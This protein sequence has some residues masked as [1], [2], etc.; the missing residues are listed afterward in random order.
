MCIWVARIDGTIYCPAHRMIL[1][2]Y[3]TEHYISHPFSFYQLT[4]SRLS[5]HSSTSLS[6]LSKSLLPPTH[7]HATHLSS[8]GHLA[9]CEL[10]I[11]LSLSL[12]LGVCPSLLAHCVF[13]AVANLCV[14]GPVGK[15]SAYC[16]SVLRNRFCSRRIG[17]AWDVLSGGT[18][19]L[20][21]GVSPCELLLNTK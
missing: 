8:Q 10:L 20:R 16:V 21:S 7:P 3:T 13:F 17:N 15:C 14:S 4:R 12:F 11:S 5:I 18:R 19:S 6:P 2:G 1:S 9:F